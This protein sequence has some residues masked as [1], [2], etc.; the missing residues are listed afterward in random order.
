MRKRN[1]G[2]QSLVKKVA[3]LNRKAMAQE[4]V[5]NL[6]AYR[7]ATKQTESKNILIVDDEPVMRNAIKRIFEKENYRVLLAQDAM[8]LSKILESTKL[9]ILLL[10]INLPWVSGYEV[11]SLLKSQPQLKNLPIIIYI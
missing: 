2:N 8:E 10:D 5:V 1:Y 6:D 4:R 7:C 3:A 11:C 9:D